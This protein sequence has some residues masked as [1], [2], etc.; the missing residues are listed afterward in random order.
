MKKTYNKPEF[1]DMTDD[2]LMEAN[3]GGFIVVVG[4]AVAALVALAGYTTVAIN[5][6]AIVNGAWVVNVGTSVSVVTKK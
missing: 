6:V 2:E 5:A 3:G 4:A 1:V